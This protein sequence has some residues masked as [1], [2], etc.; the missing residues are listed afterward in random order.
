MEM[1]EQD[2][3]RSNPEGAIIVAL[4]DQEDGLLFGAVELRNGEENWLEYELEFESDGETVS[5]YRG[6]ED[7][8]TLEYHA[9]RRRVDTVT[10]PGR[11]LVFW[12]HGRHSL[13][14]DG[15]P[16]SPGELT[17]CAPQGAAPWLIR[18]ASWLPEWE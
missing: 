18:F 15:D 9:G 13:A 6:A 8:P 1:N 17:A 5:L 3:F 2:F 12:N 14:V 16:L 7:T 4:D 11:L 10:L